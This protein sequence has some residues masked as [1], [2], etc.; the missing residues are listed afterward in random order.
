MEGGDPGSFGIVEELGWIK[1]KIIF[2]SQMT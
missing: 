2:S 1:N